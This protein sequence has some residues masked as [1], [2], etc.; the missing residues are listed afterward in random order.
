MIFQD[1][2]LFTPKSFWFAIFTSIAI[3]LVGVMCAKV[4]LVLFERPTTDPQYRPVDI[5]QTAFAAVEFPARH[6]RRPVA[7]NCSPAGKIPRCRINKAATS[8]S[9]RADPL[10]R[11][12]WEIKGE[13]A[14]DKRLLQ[15]A[16]NET[17]FG[18]N[19][20]GASRVCF[21]WNDAE[22]MLLRCL[23]LAS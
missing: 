10:A 18:D 21:I 20:D 17:A 3:C 8:S 22:L 6:N 11:E 2:S 15:M 23:S 9:S 5:T 16:R 1:F 13:P 4:L 7:L 14:S 19:A 12:S